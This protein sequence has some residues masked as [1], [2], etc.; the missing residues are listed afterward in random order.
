[1]R[2]GPAFLQTFAV[3]IVQTAAS[4]LTGVLIARGL[5]PAGQGHYALFA[6][7]ITFAVI[8]ASFGQFEGNVLSS[9]GQSGPGRIL[10]VRAILHALIVALILMVLLPVWREFFRRNS[11]AEA[12][13]LFT[14]VLTPD[15][16]GLSRVS[17]MLGRS[18]LS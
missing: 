18:P 16:H 10:L 11:M 15:R 5:G 12:S 7:A 9:A 3:Q 8:V 13:I 14:L 6:A 4:I 1:M 2:V 17:C